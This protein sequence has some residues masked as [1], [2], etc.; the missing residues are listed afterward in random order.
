MK[1][2]KLVVAAIIGSI[3]SGCSVL[4]IK[5]SI[6]DN[7]FRIENFMDD[8]GADKEYVYL[9]CHKKRVTTWSN[10]KQFMA[11]KHN[12]WVKALVSKRDTAN[13]QRVAYVN[14]EIELSAGESYTL[15]RKIDDEQ[16]SI[17]IQDSE[18]GKVVSKV[19]VAKLELPK[20]VDKR[21]RREQCES[22]TI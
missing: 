9:M 11:G 1:S 5:S 2:I 21:L 16:I 19:K 7:H 17:W 6:K 8:R 4:P 18:N 10:P 22:G 13:S 12:L 3:V 20:V 15:N 14:F